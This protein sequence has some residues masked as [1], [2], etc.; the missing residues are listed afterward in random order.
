M[1]GFV[2]VMAVA[3]M[4][5]GSASVVQAQ[6]LPSASDIVAK[7]VTAIGG[8]D[9]VLKIKSM[10]QQATMEI[11]TAGLTAEMQV[12]QAAPNMLSS[13]SSIAGIG[14]MVQGFNGTVGWEINP[15]Q[16]PRLYTA[17]EVEQAKENNDLH[18][19]RLFPAD[20]YSKMD[21]LEQLDF[22]GEKAYKV[23]MVRKSG[24]EVTHYFSTATGLLIGSDVTQESPMGT[25]TMQM[26]FSK[27]EEKEGVKFPTRTE[28]TM[29]P[30]SII[31][32]VKSTTF[33]D[34]PATAFEVPA[35]IKPLIAK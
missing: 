32:T 9:N 21:V 35:A 18:S 13:K 14:E 17:K 5:I 28:M 2:R 10:T 31:T 23:K 34:V 4:T 29:G 22:N 24:S 3:A 16:G 8:R 7:Y 25:L 19:S 15:M 26:K 1:K 12:S 27:F 6:A 20:Q 33:N 30:N 11:P